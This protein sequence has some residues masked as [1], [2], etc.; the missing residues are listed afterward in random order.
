M[1]RTG[2]LSDFQ[3]YDELDHWA[4]LGLRLSKR[5]FPLILPR[6]MAIRTRYI[7]NW[8]RNGEIFS[9]YGEANPDKNYLGIEVH[10]PGVGACI[11][12]I[13]VEKE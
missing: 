4:D 5:P 13:A 7:R 10:T 8:L 12:A 3:K 1:L 11:A 2:R 6:F 9:G